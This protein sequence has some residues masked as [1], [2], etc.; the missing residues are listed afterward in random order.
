MPMPDPVPFSL[1]R[2]HSRP[3]LRSAVLA[4]LIP[5]LAACASAPSEDIPAGDSRSVFVTAPGA[6]TMTLTREANIS[7]VTLPGTPARLWPRLMAAFQEFDL[8]LNNADTSRRILVSGANRVRRIAD[9]KVDRYFECP[10]TAYGNTASSGDVWVTVQAQ[11]LAV[12]DAETQL[13]MQVEANSL[14][15]SGNR[16]RC[17]SNERL[18]KMLRDALL[19]E[20]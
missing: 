15:H 2:G 3:W 10:G 18:E 9:M 8:P 20:G 19:D 5:A 13:R 16:S 14:S 17:R 6:E 4:A 1:P 7:S 12:G 11:L